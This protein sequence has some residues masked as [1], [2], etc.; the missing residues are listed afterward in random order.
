MKEMV[1]FDAKSG[2]VVGERS[3]GVFQRLFGLGKN[4]DRCTEVQ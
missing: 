1:E 2:G 4:D 3:V